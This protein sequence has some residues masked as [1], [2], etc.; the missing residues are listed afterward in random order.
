[1]VL[2]VARRAPQVPPP[3]LE[4]AGHPLR[5][6]L[7]QELVGS[8]RQVGEL[9][10]LV[11]EPQ[12]LVSYH[13]ARLRRAGLVT[14][15]ASAADG[16][17]A[18]YHVDLLRCGELLAVAGGELHPAL[19]PSE[20]A[21]SVPARG[22]SHRTAGSRDTHP[23]RTTATRV[24]R[25]L[26]LCTG[27]SARSQMAEA[28]AVEL[29]SEAVEARSAGSHPKALHRNA[30]EV[31]AR[32]GIDISGASTKHLR[33]FSR[34]RFDHVVTLCDRVREVC[35]E[36]RGHPRRVHWSIPDP[37]RGGGSDAETYPAFERTARELEARVRFLLSAL[38]SSPRAVRA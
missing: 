9:T 34:V 7:L 26:F 15:Q 5:W 2:P 3:F 31:M 37:A 28:L 6:R 12:S 10:E 19:G 20:T 14:A 13:L 11:G 30:V 33:T 22:G 38:G 35:P 18:Y 23:G 32:W 17:R 25:L 21:T 27:N 8:D 36:F 1:M 4:L 29:S 24:P 16:R